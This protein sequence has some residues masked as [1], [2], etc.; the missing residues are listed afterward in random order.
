MIKSEGFNCTEHLIKASGLSTED[1]NFH[2]VLKDI[3]RE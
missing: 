3:E 2:T 1:V